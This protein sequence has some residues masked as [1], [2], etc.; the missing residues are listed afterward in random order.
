MWCLPNIDLL[1]PGEVGSALDICGK[2]LLRHRKQGSELLW[3][4][5]EAWR[6]QLF[7]LFPWGICPWI[8]FISN[9]GEEW[10]VEMGYYQFSFN[11][12]SPGLILNLVSPL[13]TMQSYDRH[14]HSP[15]LRECFKSM[16]LVCVQ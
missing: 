1:D 11:Q 12:T 5:V 16:T 4:R 6:G 15:R 13:L 3:T 7:L 10:Q 2:Q 14:E 8:V 9:H